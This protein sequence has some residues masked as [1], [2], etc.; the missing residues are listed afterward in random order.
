MIISHYQF[1]CL[2]N[3]FQSF[4]FTVH[5]IQFIHLIIDFVNLFDLIHN[6]INFLVFIFIIIDLIIH[7]ITLV[8]IINN[9][10]RLKFN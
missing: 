6:I 7:Q 3:K 2:T 4:A 8:V 10:M 1:I 9:F 5:V